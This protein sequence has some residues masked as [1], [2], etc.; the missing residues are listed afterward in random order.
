MK[1]LIVSLTINENDGEHYTADDYE[2][3]ITEAI[4]NNTTASVRWYTTLKHYTYD[5]E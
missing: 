4:M 2:N 1:R 5:E 3:I